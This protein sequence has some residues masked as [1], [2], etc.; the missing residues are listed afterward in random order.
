MAEEAPDPATARAALQGKRVAL[1]VV[2]A[3]AVIF[4]LATALHVIPAVFGAW[5]SPIRADD[6]RSADCARGL[7]ELE[8]ALDRDNPASRDTVQYACSLTPEGL[9]A[10]ASFERLRVAGQQLNGRDPGAVA[11]LKR[12]LAAHLPSDSR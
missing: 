3:A 10:W 8:R 7:R 9:Q 12:D 6:L 2:I 4:I 5:I 11:Q 1:G